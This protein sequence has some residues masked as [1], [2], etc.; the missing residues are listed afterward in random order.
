MVELEGVI[1]KS[2]RRS[3]LYL[4]A[5]GAWG[6]GG[7]KAKVMDSRVHGNDTIKSSKQQAASSLGF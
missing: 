1:A 4:T 3:N 2:L 7:G 5:G 6:V